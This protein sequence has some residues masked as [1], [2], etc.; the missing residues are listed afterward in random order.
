MNTIA[1]E[2]TSNVSYIICIPDIYYI[3]N[4]IYTYII[5]KT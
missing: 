2:V 4:I 1:H 5:N 3:V